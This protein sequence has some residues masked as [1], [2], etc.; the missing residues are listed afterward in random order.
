MLSESMKQSTN[1]LKE[2]KDQLTI[3]AF[4]ALASSLVTGA[5][6]YA[7]LLNGWGV[8]LVAATLV[9]AAFAARYIWAAVRSARDLSLARETAESAVP[10]VAERVSRD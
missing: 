8:G 2:I 4:V 7:A 1:P 10:P 3:H 9:P 6:I 5:F